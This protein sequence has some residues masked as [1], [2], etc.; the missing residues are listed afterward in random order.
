MIY[1][2]NE[3]EY[4]DYYAFDEGGDEEGEGED[5]AEMREASASSALMVSP[6]E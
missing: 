3:E 1:E 2:G 4:E 6:R 5:D